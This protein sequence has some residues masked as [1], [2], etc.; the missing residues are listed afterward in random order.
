[1]LGHVACKYIYVR[2]FRGSDKMHRRDL[3]S[4]GSWVAICLFVWMVSW[5]VAESIPVFNDLLSLIVSA[6]VAF[7]RMTSPTYANLDYVQ[8]ALF[9]SWFSCKIPLLPFRWSSL[10]RFVVGFPAIFWLHMNQGQYFRN[11]R[12]IFLTALNVAILAI[13]CAIVS[14]PKPFLFALR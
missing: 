13:A 5:V 14:S 9:G 2:L 1:M 3:T 11:A 4:I 7:L 12:K 10:T 8:S 6:H